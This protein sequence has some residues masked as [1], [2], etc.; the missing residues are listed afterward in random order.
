M[1]TLSFITNRKIFAMVAGSLGTKGRVAG[2]AAAV[3]MAVFIAWA[4]SLAF[5]T[6]SLAAPSSAPV[7]AMT[8]QLVPFG[9]PDTCKDQCI[10][11]ISAEGEITNATPD[12]FLSFVKKTAKDSRVRSVIFIH[13]PGG[14][15]LASMRLGEMFRTFGALAIVGRLK[16]GHA[17]EGP[18]SYIPGAKCYS[19]CVYA[20]IGAKKRIVPPTS[21]VGIHRMFTMEAD[22]GAS[23]TG[24]EHKVYG[25]REFIDK[26]ASYAKMMGVSSDLVWSAEKVD[27]EK[28][29]IVTPKE[30]R[31]WHLG[32][33]RF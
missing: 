30:L 23:A 21:L 13:S 33:Q 2:F 32:T 6:V 27:S 3:V 1:L 19:A 18:A 5:V 10:R 24:K 17:G 4:A 31:R 20:L 11:V 25:D 15:V 16:Q 29:H 14:G 26:L 28:I 8:F 22:V 7:K 9:D 12:D